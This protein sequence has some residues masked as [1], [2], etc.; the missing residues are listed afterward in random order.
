MENE[1]KIALENFIAAKKNYQKSI[2][3]QKEMLNFQNNENFITDGEILKCFDIDAIFGIVNFNELASIFYED[4]H[5]SYSNIKPKVKNFLISCTDNPI[6]INKLNFF[7][8]GE[9]II[10]G[11][12]KIRIFIISEKEILYAKKMNNVLKIFNNLESNFLNLLNYNYEKKNYTGKIE[13][14]KFCTFE[15]CLKMFFNSSFIYFEIFGCKKNFNSTSLTTLFSKV[16]RV[17]NI[18][19]ENVMVDYCLN[20]FD[21]KK[22]ILYPKF[23]TLK[24]LG[25]KPNY[26]Q[27][28]STKCVG[29]SRYVSKYVSCSK[30]LSVFNISKIYLYSSTQD[31]FETITRK[32]FYPTLATAV[33]KDL[34]ADDR[35][36]KNFL[37]EMKKYTEIVQNF[38]S[39]SMNKN[40][41]FSFRWEFRI[42]YNEITDLLQKMEPLI[43]KNSFIFIEKD[44]FFKDILFNLNLFFELIYSIE[45]AIINTGKFV[46]LE[47]LLN[48]SFL[49]GDRF[50]MPFTNKNIRDLIKKLYNYNQTEIQKNLITD[51]I[52][53]NDHILV[54]ENFFNSIYF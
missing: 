21:S 27:Y 48:S 28:F 34:F 51:I 15:K 32:T 6:N 31:Y 39:A 23:Q 52:N 18:Q 46:I 9:I 45:K 42:K 33:L 25:Q 7:C 17:I 5:I 53:N 12:S 4:I 29:C 47:I 30:Y 8:F 20:T 36:F 35:K 13:K 37:F 41:F 38:K 14:E 50:M 10:P 49:R 11:T 44:L 22:N 43:E 19:H 24:K 16:N 40:E 3:N 1:I 54:F 26:F 2:P